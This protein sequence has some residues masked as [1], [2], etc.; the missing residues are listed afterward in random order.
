M[1]GQTI[2][3]LNS[4]LGT[5]AGR[6]KELSS[7]IV[8]FNNFMAGLVQDKDAILGSLDSISGLANQTA[9][10]TTGSG[11]RWSRTSRACARSR[12]T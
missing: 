2:D 3:N 7:L 11:R 5:I 6:D 1:I 12:P 4:V 9:D 10:L 8:E